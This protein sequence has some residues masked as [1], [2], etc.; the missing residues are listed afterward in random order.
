MQ[1]IKAKSWVPVEGLVDEWQGRF[2]LAGPNEKVGLR[3]F[4][5]VATTLFLLLVVSYI[6][7]MDVGDWR[8][9]A[10]TEPTM[11]KHGSANFE[12]LWIA[13]CKGRR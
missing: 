9:P 1:R 5:A 13:V 4:L 10:R 3:V 2:F 8:P 6:V 7:R 12:Q 11:D